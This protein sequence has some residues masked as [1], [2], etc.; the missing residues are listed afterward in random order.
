MHG[1]RRSGVDEALRHHGCHRLGRV[2]GR[3]G[4]RHPVHYV[5]E[6]A[7]M[8]IDVSSLFEHGCRR[9]RKPF[10][11]GEQVSIRQHRL[12]GPPRRFIPVG[13]PMLI[14]SAYHAKCVPPVWW[15]RDQVAGSRPA[16]DAPL[17][18][19]PQQ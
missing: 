6:Q 19:V 16:S 12:P 5:G 9:C 8:T 4:V 15:H 17:G 13:E 7:P 1:S 10:T 3:V 2:R 11:A 14:L 18:S